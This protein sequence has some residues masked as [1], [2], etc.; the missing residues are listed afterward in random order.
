MHTVSVLVLLSAFAW[1]QAA[2]G[3]VAPIRHYVFFGQDRESIRTTA[4][5]LET[6]GFA[7]AQVTYP[8]RQ[9]EPAR[10]EYDFSSIRE[11]LAFLSARGKKLWIQVQDVT[12]SEARINV[13]R[14]LLEDPRFNG[15]ADR[16]FH[17]G[18]NDE[19]PVVEG[20]MARR[21]DPAVQERFHKL[22]SALGAEFDGR[23]EGVNLAETAA[24]FGQ[25]GRLYP[26]GFTPDIYRDAI[27]ANMRALKRAFPT[28]IAMQ[29]A[30]FMPGGTEPLR[31]VYEAARESNVGV[32]GPDLLPFR[33]WQR[34]NSYPLIKASSGQV[35]T[36]IAVQDGNYADPD[37]ATGRRASAAELLAFASDELGVDYICQRS[38]ETA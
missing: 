38:S 7:G 22:L 34:I 6:A 27:V 36:G 25:T 14:Y 15:G 21:W 1:G 19:N 37:P 8:W 30:N 3:R 20:W 16:Q 5:F 35:P 4:G 11:D 24:G 12:F 23:I 33:R 17:A 18:D 28:S 29:Y 26:K 9:L 32:G 2:P 31:R 13:P 10:D